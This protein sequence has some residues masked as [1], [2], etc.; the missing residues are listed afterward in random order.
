MKQSIKKTNQSAKILE[1]YA[2]CK[3][4]RFNSNNNLLHTR[5]VPIN[6]YNKYTTLDYTR[7]H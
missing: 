3:I 7:T 5:L 1:I 4:R 2:E 6:I